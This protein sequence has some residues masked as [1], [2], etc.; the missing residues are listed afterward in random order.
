MILYDVVRWLGLDSDPKDV[1]DL[2]IA[3]F[4]TFLRLFR[5]QNFFLE[6]LSWD[7]R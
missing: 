1:C 4:V 2:K 7:C 6:K 3:H 5:S